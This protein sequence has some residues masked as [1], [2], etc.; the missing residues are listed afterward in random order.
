MSA[1]YYHILGVKAEAK[2]TE[3]KKAYHQLAKRYHPDKNPDNPAAAEKFRE[4]KL[5]YDVLSDESRRI[6]YD[7]LLANTKAK[8][9]DFIPEPAPGRERYTPAA[10]S[11]ARLFLLIF[12]TVVLS[13]PV[14]LNY[15]MS[16]QAYK[17]AQIAEGKGDYIEAIFD[18]RRAI[19]YFGGKN[20]EAALAGAAIALNKLKDEEAA[21][22]FL[23]RGFKVAGNKYQKAQLYM[24]EAYV[25]RQSRKFDEALISYDQVIQLG[26]FIDSVRYESAYIL[27]YQLQRC[28]EARK[29]FEDMI[30]HNYKTT[31]A[32]IA[33]GWC[34]QQQYDNQKAL[35]YFQRAIAYDSLNAEAYFMAGF[36]QIMLKENDEACMMLAKAMS[37]NHKRAAEYFNRFCV[38]EE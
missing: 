38:K 20:I 4:I 15:I 9:G 24:M 29:L 23:G 30:A 12:F 14:F 35:N 26:Y 18:Y 32:L 27:N 31:D 34:L 7:L 11:Y 33:I 1:N 22:S 2:A 8:Y 5:A 28:N 17:R 16:K 3:I 19:T 37:L 10:K 25:Y 6:A 21:H 13:S 36:S